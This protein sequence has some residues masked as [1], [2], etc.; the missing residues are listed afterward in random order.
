MA[1]SHDM[2]R[3]CMHLHCMLL[4]AFSRVAD[5]GILLQDISGHDKLDATSSKCL[6]NKKT[7]TKSL[8]LATSKTKKQGTPASLLHKSVSVCVRFNS[9]EQIN[10]LKMKLA[11]S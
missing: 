4:G 3:W 6:A 10:G 11:A 1:V 2:C 7:V 8:L 5:V 9:K